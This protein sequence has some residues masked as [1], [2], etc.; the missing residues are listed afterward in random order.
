[1][2]KDSKVGG[3]DRPRVGPKIKKAP[4]NPFDKFAN[5]KK[6]HE[7]VNRRVKGED[8]DVG[9]AKEKSLQKRAKRLEAEYSS[10]KKSNAFVD[11]RFGETDANLSLEDKMFLRFQ[12]ERSS[13]LRNSSIFNLD[14]LGDREEE[15]LT[16]KGQVLGAATVM[17]NDFSDD[18][19]YGNL[20]KEVVD[21]LHFGGLAPAPARSHYGPQDGSGALA[22][23][24]RA[25][26]LAEIVMKSKLRKEEKREIRQQADEERDQ[27]DAAFEDLVGTGDL[28]FRPMGRA[29][30]REETL[31]LIRK[32]DEEAAAGLLKSKKEK[33]GDDWNTYDTDMR[34]MLYEGKHRATDRTKTDEELAVEARDKLQKAEEQR[35]RRMHGIEDP[36]E[37][38]D[39]EGKNK[40]KRNRSKGKDST[41]AGDDDDESGKKDRFGNDIE[42]A[43]QAKDAQKA[44]TRR[45]VTDDD[46][47]GGPPL[48]KSGAEWAMRHMGKRATEGEDGGE[49]DGE[50]DDQDDDEIQDEEWEWDE[51]DDDDD[52][53]GEGVDEEGVAEED[54]EEED[55]E[56]ED[57]DEDGDGGDRILTKSP[58]TAI[59]GAPSHDPTIPNPD[60]PM[61]LDCPVN[62]DQFDEMT[63]RYVRSSVD[64]KALIDRVLTWNSVNLPPPAGHANREKM[65]NFLSVLLRHFVT[66]GD[67][68]AVAALPRWE[69]GSIDEDMEDDDDNE[70]EKEERRQLEADDKREENDIQ[71]QLDHLAGVI[72]TLCNDLK[73]AVC[74]PLMGRTIKVMRSFLEKRLRDYSEGMRDSSTWPSLGKLLLLKLLGRVFSASDQRNSVAGP[75]SLLLAQCLTQCPVQTPQD[76]CSGLLASSI[77]V[78]TGSEAGRLVPEVFSFISSVLLVTRRSNSDDEDRADQIRQ[79]TVDRKACAWLRLVWADIDGDKDNGDE[80]SSSDAAAAADDDNDDDDSDDDCDDSD[81]NSSSNPSPY[82]RIAWHCFDRQTSRQLL[83]A[84]ARTNGMGPHARSASAGVVST[85]YTLIQ[86]LLRRF[87]STEAAVNDKN[88]EGATGLPELM[89]F[90]QVALQALH[91]QRKPCLPV[92]LQK[93]HAEVLSSILHETEIQSS[94]RRPLRWRGSRIRSIDTKAPKFDMEYKIKKDINTTYDKAKL[95]QLSRQGKREKKAAIREIRR[96]SDFVDQRRFA[97]TLAA[98][99]ARKEIRHKNYN[100]LQDEKGETNALVRRGGAEAKGGG[101]TQY[102]PMK[103][104]QRGNGKGK[105]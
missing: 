29:A 8:R 86:E 89:M 4:E 99:E 60:M 77:L 43:Q 80:D 56:E 28:A 87:S 36:E 67:A 23:K 74:A 61:T 88:G 6:K 15:V 34:E 32:E 71:N 58:P 97:E 50:D 39:D 1:M 69:V 96:D 54:D 16:H 45:R 59:T 19:D 22:P 21:N 98:H 30:K 92:S 76:L 44:L 41:G 27:L 9:R 3:K 42:T 83:D 31:E 57:E 62:I 13:R 94:E 33:G 55:E 103:R 35:L 84:T 12:K 79:L 25:E 70:E 2:G 10:S 68:L 48:K 66:V 63:E 91:P 95:K 101:S 11:K 52:D 81:I 53:E 7:V 65:H 5:S 24:T 40:G 46:I 72:Y 93:Q 47:D 38:D 51:L 102:K 85:C 82:P 17:D 64:M 37:E 18:E 100:D 73:Q 20:D 14:A 49:D 90:V 105:R 104:L 26:M 78:E 75:V